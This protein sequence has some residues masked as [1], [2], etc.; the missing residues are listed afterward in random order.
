MTGPWTRR[1]PVL[2]EHRGDV[3][4]HAQPQ[5]PGGVQERKVFPQLRLRKDRRHDLRQERDGGVPHGEALLCIIVHA[6]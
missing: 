3:V 1:Q 5:A 4:G 2:R 6:E